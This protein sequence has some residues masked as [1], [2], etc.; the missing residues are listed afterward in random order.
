MV[1]CGVLAGITRVKFGK[2]GVVWLRTCRPPHSGR[3]SPALRLSVPGWALPPSSAG[4]TCSSP[5]SPQ[6]TVRRRLSR[7]PPPLAHLVVALLRSIPL[8]TRSQSS[9]AAAH[10]PPKAESP[11]DVEVSED[12]EKLPEFASLEGV[13]DPRILRALTVAPFK[14][15]TMSAVQAQVLPLL[16]GL[17]E[18]YDP[19]TPPENPRDLLI[20]AKTGTGKTLAF[21][22][23]AVEARLKTIYAAAEKADE[24]GL[25]PSKSLAE[26]VRT[27][28]SLTHAGI[29][30]ISPTRELAT[31]IAQEAHKLV[32]HINGFGIHLFVGGE[33]KS[34]QLRDFRRLGK[35]LIVA[36]PGRLK[37]ILES[38]PDV[39]QCVSHAQTVRTSVLS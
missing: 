8:I 20:R 19:E 2:W 38:C 32:R 16:P 5:Q 18:P 1:C 12:G 34:I 11:E 24:S 29:V 36:T 13:L 33:S 3:G 15:T 28:F 21:L 23:P 30:I 9:A 7:L 31:Q 27:S 39:S 6:I 26:G 22:I 4:P 37:D 14:L 25:P 10:L 17:A 35:D